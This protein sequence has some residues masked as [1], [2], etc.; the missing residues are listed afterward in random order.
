MLQS[1]RG[2]YPERVGKV[3]AIE[4]LG[5]T[6]TGIIPTPAVSNRVRA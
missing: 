1:G 2:V 6:P 4:G 3:V 5:P